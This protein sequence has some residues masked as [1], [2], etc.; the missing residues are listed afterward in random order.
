MLI[1]GLLVGI[2]GGMAVMVYPV[3]FVEIATADKK[4]MFG[5]SCQLGFNLGTCLALLI[6]LDTIL[7]KVDLWPWA[8]ALQ[9]PFNF[10]HLLM[11]YFSVESPS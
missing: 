9:I 7:G 6:G 2:N 8:I 11:I 1:G 3:Y 10:L 5:A 4:G